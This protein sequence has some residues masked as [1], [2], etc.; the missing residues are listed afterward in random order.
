MVFMA[1]VRSIESRIRRVEGFDVVI[2]DPA[3][4]HNVRSDRERF[5][6]YEFLNRAAD[7]ETVERWKMTRFDQ[8]YLGYRCDVLDARGQRVR[9]NTRLRTVRKSYR[10]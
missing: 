10:G 5:P 3:D 1:M 7:G 8:R 4:G 2:R 9:G 6:A